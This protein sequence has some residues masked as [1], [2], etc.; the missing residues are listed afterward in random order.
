M[1]SNIRIEKRC[2]QCGKIFTAKTTVTK[3]CGADCSKRGYKARKRAEKI[4]LTEVEAK[5]TIQ[6]PITEL[7]AKEFLSIEEVCKLLGVSRTTIWRMTKSGQIQ[8]ANF[9]RRK[10][11]SKKSISELFVFPLEEEQSNEVDIT[12]DIDEC[13]YINEILSLYQISEKALYDLIKRFKIPKIKV[14]KFV[15]VPKEKIDSLL[16]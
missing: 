7:Q 6:Q 13:Y 1:S 10:L 2:L 15:Y 11:I 9:G 14:G 5:Q 12:F 3:Y 8:T 16:K 4:K